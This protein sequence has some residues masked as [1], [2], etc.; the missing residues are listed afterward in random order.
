MR[1][2]PDGNEVTNFLIPEDRRE[3]LRH[4]GL[5][6][7]LLCLSVCLVALQ[8]LYCCCTCCQCFVG[9]LHP[10]PLFSLGFLG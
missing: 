1:Y 10:T 6:S 3:C 5:V 9:P 2:L 7:D 4:N 8:Y